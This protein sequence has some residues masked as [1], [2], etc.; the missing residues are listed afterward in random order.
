M[1]F[2]DIV[3]RMGEEGALGPAAKW[4]LASLKHGSQLRVGV[5][6]PILQVD[7]KSL[8]KSAQS[9]FREFVGDWIDVRYEWCSLYE[10]CQEGCKKLGCRVQ[11]R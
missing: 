10:G 2:P 5:R 8:E 4:A 11:P 1:T 9:K 3:T 6:Q 7:P